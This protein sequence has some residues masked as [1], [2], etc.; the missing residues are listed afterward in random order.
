MSEGCW[1]KG[2]TVCDEYV[3][4]SPRDDLRSLVVCVGWLVH[5]RVLGTAHPPIMVDVGEVPE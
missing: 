1:C 5:V 2:C 3:G 4:V